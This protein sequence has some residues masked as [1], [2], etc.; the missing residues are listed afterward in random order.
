[1]S[2]LSLFA[3]PAPTLPPSVTYPAPIEISQ[4]ARAYQPVAGVCRFCLCHGDCIDRTGDRCEWADASRNAC[5][6]EPCR[7]KLLAEKPAHTRRPK[8]VRSAK[9]ARP[10]RA[11]TAAAAYNRWL[12]S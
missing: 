1:M 9:P 10:R 6:A 7:A 12:T 5:S 3:N 11:R 2:Q 4:P 8:P